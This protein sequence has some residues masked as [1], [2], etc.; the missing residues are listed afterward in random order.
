M[1]NPTTPALDI[2]EALYDRV[3]DTNVKKVQHPTGGVIRG[4]KN[5]VRKKPEERPAWLRRRASTSAKIVREIEI[6]PRKEN[7]TAKTQKPKDSTSP[8][9]VVLTPIKCS[10]GASYSSSMSADGE[11]FDRSPA[12]FTCESSS[13]RFTLSYP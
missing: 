5:A 13:E 4:R 8:T 9:R 1:T 6:M 3:V 10:G 12:V 7:C 2:D 11:G